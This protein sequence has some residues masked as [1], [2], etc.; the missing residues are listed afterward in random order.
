[1]QIIGC[2]KCKKVRDS[3]NL[4]DFL[5]RNIIIQDESIK[6]HEANIQKC[7]MVR[8]MIESK[9]G[10]LTKKVEQEEKKL[11]AKVGTFETNETYSFQR[12]AA[13]LKEFQDIN[14]FCS[15]V[16]SALNK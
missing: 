12:K 3:Q 11:L 13:K 14:T 10:Y 7:K 4:V 9:Y 16:N 2:L 1:M 8:E 15:T 5:I 6:R